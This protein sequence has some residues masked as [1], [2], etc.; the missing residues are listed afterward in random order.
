ML[1]LSAEQDK[2]P[3]FPFIGGDFPAE[4]SPIDIIQ[5]NVKNY[6]LFLHGFCKK[7]I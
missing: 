6:N 3:L 7:A 2:K 4:I 5:K 1:P